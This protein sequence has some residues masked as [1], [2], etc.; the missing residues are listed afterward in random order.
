MDPSSN[1]ADESDAGWKTYRR[2]PFWSMRVGL[3]GICAV[4]VVGSTKRSQ[5]RGRCK[6]ANDCVDSI[7]GVRDCCMLGGG[8]GA[9]KEARTFSP[10]EDLFPPWTAL[11]DAESA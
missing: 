9:D 7:D 10:N 6:S 1:C 11:L 4:V 2:V 8:A 5:T 3:Y